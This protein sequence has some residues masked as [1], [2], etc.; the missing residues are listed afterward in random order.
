MVFN[1]GGDFSALSGATALGPE[2]LYALRMRISPLAP[3]ARD[4]Y[5]GLAGFAGGRGVAVGEPALD[6]FAGAEGISGLSYALP[7]EFDPDSLDYALSPLRGFSLL[8]SAEE[9]L[10]SF[11]EIAGCLRKGGFFAFDLDNCSPEKTGEGTMRVIGVARLP[12]G[13]QAVLSESRSTLPGGRKIFCRLGV[14]ELD[15]SGKV[16]S[17][18]YST[19]ALLTFSHRKVLDLAKSAGF[20]AKGL[21]GGFNMEP[22]DDSSPTQLWLFRKS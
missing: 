4:F 21:Y 3:P 11:R 2:K 13:T 5:L 6:F 17:K 19:L 7:G 22:F 8:P 14:E 10:R 20:E 12:G 9:T 1:R 15:G 18:S 16:R